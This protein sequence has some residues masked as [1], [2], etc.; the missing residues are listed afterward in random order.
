[1][2]VG[3]EGQKDRGRRVRGK[4]ESGPI[5]SPRKGVNLL[6]FPPAPISISSN[7]GISREQGSLLFFVDR[8]SNSTFESAGIRTWDILPPEP[9]LQ[10]ATA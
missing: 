3:D 1:M 10:V 8:R 4:V 7:R 2:V 6:F 9:M 5:W